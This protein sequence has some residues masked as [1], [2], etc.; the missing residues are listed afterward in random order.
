MEPAKPRD[1]TG[2][3]SLAPQLARR[4]TSHPGECFTCHRRDGVDVGIP[5]ITS[6]T[7]EELLIALTLYKTGQR[8]NKVV[9]SVAASKPGPSPRNVLGF[10]QQTDRRSRR[11]KA[12]IPTK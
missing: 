11:R 6:M 7:E 3:E 9:A 8:K 2:G 1:R 5:G 12:G 4:V 10:A